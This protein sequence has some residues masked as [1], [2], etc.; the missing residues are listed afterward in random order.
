MVSQTRPAWQLR[1]LRWSAYTIAGLLLLALVSWLALPHFVKKIAIEQTQEKIGRKIAIGDVNFNPFILALKVSDFV[2]YEPDQTTPAFSAKSL[3]VNASS[4]SLFRLAAVL[5]EVKL[6]SPNLHVVRLSADGIGRYNFSDIIDRILALPKTEGSTSFSLSNV[7]LQNGAIV[8]DDKVTGKQIDI[9]ALN[10]GVP[11]VSNFP[12]SIDTFVQPNLSATINGAPFALKGRSKPFAD[13]LE[14]TLG[15]DID[16]LDLVSYLPFVPVALPVKLQ[17]ARLSTKLDLSF[18]RSADKPQIGLAGDINLDD[19]SVQDKQSAPL[20][21]TRHLNVKLGKLDVLK[22]SG[23]I[24]QVSI[25]SPEIWAAMNSK[26]ELNWA[27][28]AGSNSTTK[29]APAK[30]AVAAPAASTAPAAPAAAAAPTQAAATPATATAPVA[31]PGIVLTKL[32]VRDGIVHWSDDANA[33]PRQNVSLGKLTVDAEQISTAANAKP[34]TVSLSVIENDKG[35]ISFAG[36]VDPLKANVDGKITLSG[37]ELASYQNYVNRS[38]RAALSGKVSGETEAKMS[39]GQLAL[40]KL[41]VQVEQL[42]LAPKSGP[43]LT[44]KNIALDNA[45]LDLS[46]RKASADALRV[47]GIN[48]DLRRNTKG[49]LNLQDM[50]PPTAA[51]KTE[52]KS[53]PK[54]TTKSAAATEWQARLQTFSI[55]DSVVAYEDSSVTPVQKI[56]AEGINLKLENLSSLLDQQ[57][58]LSLQT[59]LNKNGKLTVT[60]QTAPHL[61]NVDLMLDGQNI[62]IAPFQA[63]FTEF[64]NVTLT[65]G[66]LSAKGKIA[67]VPPVNKQT[68]A[69]NYNGSASLNNFRI[70]DKLSATDF[71]RWKTLNLSGINAK[72]GGKPLI[73]LDKVALSDFYARAILS[74][75]GKLNLQDIVVSKTPPTVPDNAPPPVTVA[76]TTT[77]SEPVTPAAPDPNAPVIRIG[78]IALQGGNINF[79]DNFVKPNYSANMTG[80]GGTIGAIA[81]DKPEPAPI[82][83]RGKIDNDA[84]LLISGTLNP[85]FKPMFLDIKASAS[86]VELPRLTP[87]STKYAGY[88]ITK[89]KLSMDVSYKIEDEKLVAQNDVRIDQL[90]F[91]DR[92]DGPDATKLPVMLA[93]ALLKDRNG[94]IN[95]NL[96]ISGSLSDPQ[97]SI[98]GII[99]RIFVNLIV[100]AVTS[101]FA[102]ISSAFGGGEELSYVEFAPG[103]AALTPAITGKLDSITKALDDRPALKLDIIGRVDPNVD[104]EGLRLTSLNRKIRT[105]KRKDMIGNDDDGTGPMKMSDAER[106]KYLEKVYKDTKFDKPRNAIGFAKSLPPEEMEKLLIANTEVK[107]EDLRT[108]ALARADAVRGYLEQQGKISL[109]RI[110]LIAPKLNADDIKDKSPTSRV[111]FSLK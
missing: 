54:S 107:P 55:A 69:L 96:P 37:I 110:F 86:G 103:S 1:T 57:S 31:A 23:L 70:L 87:Y 84:P 73:T 19:L 60:G 34:A 42:K 35:T 72:I 27:A 75:K 30:P 101:P 9:K 52:E 79:T 78:Q 7:Q 98:G 58:K 15:I 81:S 77:S 83:L 65:S 41:N 59:K 2:L 33:A 76:K 51:T 46:A 80:M 17:S 64:L 40:G 94:Q 4:T 91:G 108:L 25:D 111:D 74:D 66:T 105:L 14:T 95:L 100:K 18:S 99:M 5:D 36:Q 10:I 90:T 67:M 3:T 106:N 89:G 44:V 24:D 56:R 61:K 62:P 12:R 8:F 20:L 29:T 11:V 43:A 85:L 49:E 109:E 50:L 92:I 26:D 28:L 88:P 47:S 16:K 53:A 97:F 104:T 71:L 63:Y 13:S 93:V 39:G 38:L 45:S 102:L 22:A 32:T 68:L 6:E 82:D 21:K 48:G